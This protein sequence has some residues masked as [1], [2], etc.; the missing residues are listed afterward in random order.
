MSKIVSPKVT[1]IAETRTVSEYG[2]ETLNYIPGVE[3]YLQDIGCEGWKT[4]AYTDLG[5]TSDA[6]ELI[7]FA[8]KMCYRSFG[9]GGNAN[10]TATREDIKEYIGNILK[11]GHGSVLEHASC[12]FLI[13]NCSRVVTHEIVRHRAGFAF[14][15]ESLRFV[16]L[17]DLNI[18]LPDKYKNL[19][20]TDKEGATQTF[21]EFFRHAAVAMS[22]WQVD[23]MQSMPDRV[24]CPNCAGKGEL[25]SGQELN[26][27]PSY[28]LC[29]SCMGRGTKEI[30]FNFKK[31]MTSTF[32]RVAPIGVATNILVTAN[33][34]AWRFTIALRTHKSA[35][36]EIRQVFIQIG[37]ILKDRYSHVFQDMTQLE[38]GSWVFEHKKV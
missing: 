22:A 25:I 21:E 38:D 31:E 11:V 8:G 14:S 5:Q 33:L 17:T 3:K 10:L 28:S 37:K 6:E 32:R 9:L 19:L 20:M 16:P 13:H 15:Q 27:L 18:V 23:L 30:D 24:E 34:R 4:S 7:E 35:E 2:D 36:E 12:T 29:S 26:E 1:L